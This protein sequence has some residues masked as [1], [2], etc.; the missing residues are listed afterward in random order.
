MTLLAAED[1][2]AIGLSLK[3][4]A[5]ATLFGLPIALLVAYAL[6][7][8]RFFGKA[9]LDALMKLQAKVRREPSAANLRRA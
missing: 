1:L 5:M 8:G 9:L 6:A 7:R 3:V 2:Q 4:A